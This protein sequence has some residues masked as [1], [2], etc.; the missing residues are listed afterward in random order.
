MAGKRYGQSA[1]AYVKVRAKLGKSAINVYDDICYIYGNNKV[2]YA[3][4]LK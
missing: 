3:T 2:S 4:V 1:E